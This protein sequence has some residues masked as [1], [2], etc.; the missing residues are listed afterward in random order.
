MGDSDDEYDQKRSRGRRGDGDNDGGWNDRRRDGGGWQRGNYSRNNQGYGGHR[1]QFSPP[2]RHGMGQMNKRP[3]RDW[4]DGDRDDFGDRRQ[5]GGR[6]AGLDGGETPNGPTQPALMSFRQ[7]MGT[8]DENVEQD[9]VNQKYRE[10][11]IDFK[12]QQIHEFFLAHKDE[13]WFRQKYHPEESL[14]RNQEKRMFIQQRLDAYMHLL[15]SGRVADIILE[16][17]NQKD[18]M[19]F[20]DEALIIMEGGTEEDF[21][22][23]DEKVPTESSSDKPEDEDMKE[24]ETPSEQAEQKEEKTPG[25]EGQEPGEEP[26]SSEDSKTKES[27]K[28]NAP[29][30][31]KVLYKTT[32]IFL[33]NLPP[34]ITRT[35]VEAVC[36]RFPGFVKVAIAD[37]LP[38]RRFFRRGWA[39][40]EPDVNI[41]EICWNLSNIRLRDTELGAIVN[42]DLTRRVRF[43]TGVTRHKP[44]VRSCIQLAARIIQNLDIQFGLW[45]TDKEKAE[46]EKGFMIKSRNPILKDIT[47]YLIEEGSAEEDEYEGSRNNDPDKHTDKNDRDREEGEESSATIE[48][49]EELDKVLDRL[50]LYIRIVHSLDFYNCSDYPLEDEMPNR[51]G[52]IHVRGQ[53][54]PH[55]VTTEDANTYV[56]GMENKLS[57]WLLPKQKLTN[58]EIEELGVKDVDKEVERFVESN[59]KKLSEDKWLCPL[60]G[61]KFKGPD[62][63]RKHIFNKHAEKVEE[64]KKDVEYFN[65]YL[66]DS[67][68]PSLPDHPSTSRQ[69]GNLPQGGG[70]Q[71]G[72]MPGGPPGFGGFGG[73]PMAGRL[74]FPPD[75]RMPL[76]F[77]GPF[78]PPFMGMPPM[79]PMGM[80]GG[81]FFGGRGMGPPRNF[82]PRRDGRNVVSYK[83]LD[84]PADED[85]S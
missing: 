66:L 15:K 83:D 76:P 34:N 84:A 51:C 35:E 10:Y 57:Q 39:T 82:G 26:E 37:P 41:K 80:H 40:F 13:E 36:K 65:N 49:D 74:G 78:P 58:E 38:E 29:T 5:S 21:K 20:L 61:K 11:K 46:A 31:R 43:T 53:P 55:K 45:L 44:V 70:N 69:A 42:R 2:D 64:V 19:R 59:T 28:P 79:P 6:G 9:E 85:F 8:L 62:F 71:G 7:F 56:K 18:I 14:A 50:L 47:D 24:E 4:D 22:L 33:R 30:K 48:R 1:K 17:E 3:R 75:M 72:P 23:L 27:D 16:I 63:I 52:I 12:R 73:H 77:P 32:S 81:D 67:K 60:S 54:P 25:E 68:R